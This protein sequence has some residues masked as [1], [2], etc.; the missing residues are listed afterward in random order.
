MS[1]PGPRHAASDGRPPGPG[2][3]RFPDDDGDTPAY[4][5]TQRLPTVGP[6][7]PGEYG[8]GAPAEPAPRPPGRAGRFW[9]PR[10]VPSAVTALLALALTGLLLYDVSAVRAGRHAMPWRVTLAHELARRPLD[11]A[12]VITGAAV[13]MV[14]GLWLVILALTPGLRGVLA[15]RLGPG[16]VRAGLD[17]DAAALVL[18]DRALEVPGVLTVRAA[19]GRHRAK[20]RVDSHF[21]ELDE[22]RRD[23]D[24]VLRDAVY[25]FGL[26]HA[27]RL[28]V[29]VRRAGKG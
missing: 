22:V 9:S 14:L 6:G 18:R 10:R 29:L 12:W 19:V 26:E 2:T 17:R 1:D 20:V 24:T 21:R 5:S 28:S 25:G 15:L 8:S 23:L 13:A 3:P 4:G 11:N 27:L 16:Q 7:H